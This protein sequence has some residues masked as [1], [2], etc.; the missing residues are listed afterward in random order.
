M[1]NFLNWKQKVSTMTK[2]LLSQVP[3]IWQLRDGCEKTKD[4]IQKDF[5]RACVCVQG[6][7]FWSKNLFPFV[8]KTLE[9]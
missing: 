6:S 3:S 7:D 1:F 2:E 5:V 4:I 8:M 9:N